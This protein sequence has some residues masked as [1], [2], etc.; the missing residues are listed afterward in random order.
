MRSATA[1]G[2]DLG[3][4]WTYVILARTL[5]FFGRRN[6][7]SGPNIKSSKHK[8][9]MDK[10][11]L[12]YL[13]PNH[14]FTLNLNTAEYIGEQSFR[15]WPRGSKVP[16]QIS[17][18]TVPDSYL[19][20][21]WSRSGEWHS[22][23]WKVTVLYYSGKSKWVGKVKASSATLFSALTTRRCSGGWKLQ[24]PETPVVGADTA[25]EIIYCL[26]LQ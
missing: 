14:L 10:N 13:F 19:V 21:E 6:L 4:K 22:E 16:P 25:L 3:C 7:R 11:G 1:Y 15:S 20:V 26:Q 9:N 2:A 24:R 17:I 23:V 18:I 5:P 12:L 8:S